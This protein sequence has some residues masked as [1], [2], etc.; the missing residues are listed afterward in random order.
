MTAARTDAVIADTHLDRR[1]RLM[2]RTE[3]DRD[4]LFGVLALHLDLIDDHQFV[5][6]CNARSGDGEASCRDRLRPPC[7]AR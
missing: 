1:S 2:T 3:T 7:L 5:E 4:L 6:A